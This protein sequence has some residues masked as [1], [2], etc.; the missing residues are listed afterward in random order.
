MS[1]FKVVFKFLYAR[2]YKIL[3]SLLILMAFAIRMALLLNTDDFH[4]IS[5]GRLL[6]AM[7][8]LNGQELKSS[9]DP[10]HPPVHIAL[11]V[12]GLRIIKNPAITPRI[13][14]LIFALALFF[15]FYFYVKDV[16][17]KK[18]AIFS[19]A[20]L[21]FYSEHVVYSII[22]TSETIFHFFLFLGFAFLI[23]FKK[24]S[25]RFCLIISGL[26]LCAAS[27][28][29]YEGLIF[30][31]MAAFFIKE[32]KKNLVVFLVISLILPILWMWLN[33]HYCGN[34]FRFISANNLTVPLQYNWVRSQGI[35]ID[36]WTKLLFWPRSLINTLGLPV[37]IFGLAGVI[38]CVYKKINIPGVIIFLL[39]FLVFIVETLLERLYMQPRYSITLGLM[40]IPF[41]FFFCFK[42]MEVL[43]KKKRKIPA[44]A[45]LLLAASMIPAINGRLSAEPLSAPFFAKDIAA[46]LNKNV[47]AEENIFIDHCG[48]ERYR[49]PIKVMSRLRP[50][51]FPAM[52][53]LVTKNGK[54]EVD[55]ERF[56]NILRAKHVKFLVYSPKGDLK[57]ILALEKKGADAVIDNFR[58]RRIFKSGP[59]AIYRVE[60]KDEDK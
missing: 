25:I 47:R 33:F 8:L 50:T 56:F 19:V 42:L 28:S 16:F 43:N 57:N 11:L 27:L 58:F 36:F 10:V 37:F 5:N 9:F 52:Y 22:G 38:Y 48:D 46:Y 23:M 53:Y 41:S 31:P 30:I 39:L 15:P 3:L 2:K 26:S 49:E 35:K 59:Y 1:N 12:A 44:V 45:A 54:W 51:Q 21:V 24:N 13:I 18:T 14:S 4:G 40:L 29:R 60:I 6:L 55:K 7:N 34:P 17:D 20:A 32:N